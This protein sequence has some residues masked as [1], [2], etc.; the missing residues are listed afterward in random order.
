MF[1]DSNRTASDELMTQKGKAL[2]SE[3]TPFCPGLSKNLCSSQLWDF[4]LFAQMT[5]YYF[6]FP[7]S[8]MASFGSPFVDCVQKQLGTTT[9]SCP[10]HGAGLAAS[11]SEIGRLTSRD[12]VH[13]PTSHSESSAKP[14][15]LSD[16]RYPNAQLC[17]CFVCSCSKLVSREDFVGRSSFLRVVVSVL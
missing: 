5:K 16:Y 17:Y 10:L 6:C 11:F 4:N 15:P 12:A 14:C 9:G 8:V 7:P 2:V 13:C 3:V 1:A